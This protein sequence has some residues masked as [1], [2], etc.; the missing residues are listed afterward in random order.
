MIMKQISDWEQRAEEALTS[1]DGIKRATSNPYLYTRVMSRLQ[2]PVGFWGK[3]A[4]FLSQ[5][6]FALPAVIFLL[7]LNIGVAI[8]SNARSEEQLAMPTQVMD[9]EYATLTYSLENTADR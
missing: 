8:N 2:N 5:P 4:R 7:I 6:A 1:L 3:S 9:N